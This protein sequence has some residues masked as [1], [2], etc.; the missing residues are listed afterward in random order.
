MPKQICKDILAFCSSSRNE[1]FCWSIMKDALSM[2]LARDRVAIRLYTYI[3]HFDMFRVGNPAYHEDICKAI[4]GMGRYWKGSQDVEFVH[5]ATMVVSRLLHR[6]GWDSFDLRQML[7]EDNPPM[8]E[9]KMAIKV[10]WTIE[11]GNIALEQEAGLRNV[12]KT[13]AEVTRITFEDF[14]T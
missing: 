4:I 2:Y 9:L 14:M 6:C 10:L 8:R 13:S 7:W 11:T 1:Y 12:D 5:R 3:L